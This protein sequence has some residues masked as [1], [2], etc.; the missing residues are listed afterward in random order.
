M[1][2]MIQT[3]NIPHNIYLHVPFCVKKCNYCAFY[4]RACA[5]PDWDEY[6]NKIIDEI[7][8]FG[9]LVGKYT[10]QQFFSVGGHRH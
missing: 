1:G 10:Y 6:A 8:H 9:K 7:R 2:C 4:S 5:E 3:M